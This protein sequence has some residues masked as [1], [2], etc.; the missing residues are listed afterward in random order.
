MLPSGHV[1][2]GYLTGLALLKITNPDLPPAQISQLLYWAAFFGFAPDLDEFWFFFKN[3]AF[4]V[5]PD[6]EKHHRQYPS[7]A[8]VLWLAAGLLIYFFASSDYVKFIGLLLWL[9][10]FSHFLLD[11][12]EHGI[13]WLWPFSTKLFAV[14]NPG[15]KF[16]IAEKGFIKHSLQFLQFYT[17]RLSFYLELLII[18]FAL[19]I[20][21]RY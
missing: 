17:T 4:L 19:I 8:P 1:A 21:I 5:S 15:Q 2:A 20:F 11:S 3:K 6:V 18:I 14:K 9:G 10:S 13:M 16:S 12:I 7:H